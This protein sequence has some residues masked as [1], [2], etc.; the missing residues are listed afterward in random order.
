MSASPLRIAIAGF[1][2][3]G[4]SL[5]VK[6]QSGIPGLELTA[7]GARNHATARAALPASTFVTDV[8]A[9]AEHADVIVECAPAAILPAIAEPALRAGRTVVVLSCGALLDRMD[10]RDLAAAHGGRICRT[11]FK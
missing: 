11:A 6:L 1:G 7:V 5:A 4:R 9:L 8:G 3:I 10:L 2:A